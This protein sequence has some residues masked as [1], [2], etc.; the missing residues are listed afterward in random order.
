METGKYI[1]SWNVGEGNNAMR[2]M[3]RENM[4]DSEEDEEKDDSNWTSFTMGHYLGSQ[5]Q[6]HEEM[7]RTFRVT[8]LR[9]TE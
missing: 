9:G 2:W 3:E 5:K 4:R 6:V 1:Q 7:A 8:I